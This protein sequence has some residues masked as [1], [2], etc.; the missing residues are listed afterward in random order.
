MNVQPRP[1]AWVRSQPPETGPRASLE[2]EALKHS[3]DI[4][5]AL[6][7]PGRRFPSRRQLMRAWRLLRMLD[8]RAGDDA[9]L[10]TAATTTH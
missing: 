1:A 9:D 5:R 3:G 7:T 10:P 2:R 8:R 6:M 4:V